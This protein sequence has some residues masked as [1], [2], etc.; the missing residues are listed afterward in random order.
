[1]ERRRG[2]SPAPGLKVEAGPQRLPQRVS[3]GA[4][5]ARQC[6]D[7]VEFAQIRL[8]QDGND[9]FLKGIVVDGLCQSSR[10]PCRELLESHDPEPVPPVPGGLQTQLP[11]PEPAVGDGPFVAA[12]SSIITSDFPVAAG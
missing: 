12:I 3:A 4:H 1:M 2:C 9:S 5:H 6:L 11:H 7:T 10:E 8:R